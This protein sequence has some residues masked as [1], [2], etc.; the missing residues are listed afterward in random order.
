M[1]TVR[2]VVT[3]VTG[4]ARAAISA[5]GAGL[6]R[7]GTAARA[8][9]GRIA[10]AVGPMWAR[11]RS[12]ASSTFSA[13]GA[14]FRRLPAFATT[15][16][17]GV[18]AAF[19]SMGSSLGSIF[20]SIRS[21]IS[22][23]FRAPS[24]GGSGGAG[25]GGAAGAA[26]SVVSMLGVLPQVLL[27]S[28]AIVHLT[29][30]IGN[31]LPLLQLI[32]P[33]AVAGAAGLAVFKFATNGVADALKAGIS[34][35]AEKFAEA[36]K[37]LSF[38]TQLAV[39]TMVDLQREWRRTQRAVQE[40]F[41]EGAREDLIRLSRAIQLVADR[42]LPKIASSFATVRT[43]IANVFTTAANTGQLDKIMEGVH[44]FFAGLLETVPYLLRALLDVAEVAAPSFG[45]LG[46]G[47]GGAAKKFAD[48]IRTL[49]EDGTLAKWL[50]TAKGI[51]RQV[52]EVIGEIGRVIAAI[53]SGGQKNTDDFL[54]SLRDGFARLA[55]FLESDAGQR[56]IATISRIGI[57]IVQLIE[58]VSNFWDR[59]ASA[60]D[61]IS[62]SADGAR[63]SI[64]AI[65]G[66]FGWIGGAIAQLG[67]LAGAIA[68]VAGGGKTSSITPITKKGSAGGAVPK[69][70]ASGSPAPRGMSWVGEHGRE[71]IDWGSGSSGARL[72]GNGASERMVREGQVSRAEWDRL[73]A[74]GWR[75]DPTDGMEALYPPSQSVQVSAA[76]GAAQDLLAQLVLKVLRDKL[77]TLKVVNGRVAAA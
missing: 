36:L 55:D 42:W 60:F 76:P 19:R 48:W 16:A 69:F 61:A 46:E 37:G 67:N 5:I 3:A 49:K 39:K 43:M 28:A 33:A 71:L 15:A 52:M 50:E 57:W 2:I 58:I 21:S 63:S 56:I 77:V 35:D 4:A 1:A 44:R 9:A 22:S 30:L 29:A 75:G 8:M 6:T 70:Y 20:A 62:G 65:A 64:S 72:Y 59:A 24:P 73:M 74:A 45:A 66:A 68:R 23:A 11:L 27:I 26:A 17:R 54:T 13:V 51:F 14:F 32:A 12:G 7:L 18:L 38:S 53:F 47:I 34:G 31:L 41:W 10:A 25:G 40:K